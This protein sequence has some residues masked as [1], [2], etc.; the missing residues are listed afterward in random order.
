MGVNDIGLPRIISVDD[1]ILEPRDLWQSRV[2]SKDRDRAPKVERHYGRIDWD[3]DGKSRFLDDPDK[4][5]P[6]SGWCDHWVYD[7]MRWPIPAG[8]AGVTN[9]DADNGMVGTSYDEMREGCYDQ[10]ARIADMDLNGVEASLCFPSMPRFCGQ[11]FLDRRD[12]VFALECLRIYNDWMIDEWCGGDGVGRLIPLTLIPLWDVELA[13]EEVR[14]C[15]G[16]GSHAIAFSEIPAYLGLPSA[17]SKYWDPLFAVCQQTE[18]VVNMHIGSSSTFNTTSKDA[19]HPVN[20]ALTV[21]NSQGAFIDW[22]LSGTFARFPQLRLALSE[23]QI[24][25]MPYMMERLDSIWERGD[26]YE[27]DLRVRLPEPPSAYM[28]N[29]YGC[30]FDDVH[31]LKSRDEIGMS[32]IMYEVDYPHYD[33]TFPDSLAAAERLV[34][35]AGLNEHEAW[36]LLRGNAIEC[37]RLDRFGIKR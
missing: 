36:Q 8:F 18:T 6:D 31:G 22:I 2:P 20:A 37:F 24:G 11:T 10:K 35:E 12:K 29:I 23:G 34:R 15:A 30:I 33:S 19:P 13:V 16:K 1:H 4:S 25:W 9:E 32:Q 27:A 5:S 3:M 17:H 21:Q 28:K 14:R 26:K 7:D